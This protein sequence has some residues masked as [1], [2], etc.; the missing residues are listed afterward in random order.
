MSEERSQVVLKQNEAVPATP[1]WKHDALFQHIAVGKR[2]L[3]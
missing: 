3:F 1:Q 2:M